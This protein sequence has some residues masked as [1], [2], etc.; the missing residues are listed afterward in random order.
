MFKAL[1]LVPVVLLAIC[2]PG[3]SPAARADDHHD[4]HGRDYHHLDHREVVVWHGGRWVHDWH[5]GR[6]GWWWFAG[7]GWYFYPE[8]IY[9]YPTYI[10]PAVVVQQPPPSPAGLPPAQ[11]WYYCDSPQ[12]YY[13]YV[14]SCNIAWRQV[15]ATPAP[16]APP[17]PSSS[18]P[19]PPPP[20]GP[21]DG[22]VSPGAP[23]N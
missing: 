2:L 18:A 14:A 10:P 12:G 17:A 22:T 11:F 7:G 20:P 13:P 21:S 19:P 8:P 16:Q 15:A 1:R 6:Y 3:L 23:P 5:D 9:P 4:F